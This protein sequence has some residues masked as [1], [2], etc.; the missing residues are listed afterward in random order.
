MKKVTLLMAF[1]MLAFFATQAQGDNFGKGSSAINVGIGFGNTIYGGTGYK[2]GF[3]SIS[4]S[5]EYGIVEV[6]MGSSLKGIVG[7]GGL[8][9][10]GGSKYDYAYG[11]Y[12]YDVKT[13]YFLVAARGNY[14]FIFHDKFD[15]YAGIILG[16]YFGN[17]KVTYG[18]GWPSYLGKYDDNTGGF[19][20]GAYVGARYFFTPAIAV[21]SELGWNISIFTVGVTFKF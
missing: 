20:G 13:N 2:M 4:A 15:P 16:Y 5:Y 1:F 3:P 19:H 7:V 9:G 17:H 21:F 6:P 14:H 18:P 10:F 8:V 11:I 12:G